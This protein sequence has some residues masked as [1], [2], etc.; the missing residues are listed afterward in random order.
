MQ[1]YKFEAIVP[2]D[3]Q[4]SISLPES[5]PAGAAEIIVLTKAETQPAPT[6]EGAPDNLKAFSAWLKR[7]PATP[8]SREEIDAQIREERES[9]GDA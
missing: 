6:A 2:P 9:W 5:F 8:R 4:L 7:Q 1:A 3:H